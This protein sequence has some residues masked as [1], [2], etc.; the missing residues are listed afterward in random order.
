MDDNNVLVIFDPISLL[1]LLR[2][3][4]QKSLRLCQS[5]SDWN[6]IWQDFSSCKYASIDAAAARY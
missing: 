4:V 1:I 2:G 5:K 6:E 3:L